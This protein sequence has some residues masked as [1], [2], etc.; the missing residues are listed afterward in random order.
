[1]KIA[2]IFLLEIEKNVY[3]FVSIKILVEVAGF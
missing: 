2:S 3:N 1:M